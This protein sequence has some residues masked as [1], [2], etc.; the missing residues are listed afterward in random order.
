M[1]G[2][3]TIRRAFLAAVLV[4]PVVLATMPG[5]AQA[6]KTREIKV[7]ERNLYLGTSLDGIIAAP[8]L[9]GLLAAVADAY[10]N[11]VA[12]NFTERVEVLADEIAANGPDLVALNEVEL[13]RTDFPPD[14]PATPA[15][16]VTYDFLQLLVDALALRGLHY[17]PVLQVE[18]FDGEVPSAYG[19]DVRMTDHDVILARKGGPVTMKVSRKR[20]ANFQVNLVIPT[21]TLGPV[22][23]LRGWT[24]MDVRWAGRTFRFIVTHLEAYSEAVRVAQA[25]ELL[26]GPAKTSLP[27]MI[28]GDLNALP[29]GSS[30][31]YNSLIAAG[32]TDAWVA[33]GGGNGFTCCQAGDLLNSPSQLGER[34]DLVLTRGGISSLA[35][36]LVGNKQADRTPSGLWPSDHAGVVARLLLPA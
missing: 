5:T 1:R 10:D 14:G 7:M 24:S 26:A 23:F 17:A 34:I 6:A 35:M 2:S 18:N 32:F 8:D 20:S 28:V 19:I 12:T 33:Q 30:P 11:V 3:R 29:D 16:T 9:A 25:A 21:A 4:V 27:T 36:W 13:W 22:T 15:G 31:A